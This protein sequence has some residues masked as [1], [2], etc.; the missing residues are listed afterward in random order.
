MVLYLSTS[1][2]V[3]VNHGDGNPTVV[4]G[5]NQQVNITYLNDSSPTISITNPTN[6]T[7]IDTS[8]LSSSFTI[9]HSDVN[10]FTNCLMFTNSGSDRANLT[11][12]EGLTMPFNIG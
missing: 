5:S 4:N 8:E 9:A 3:T 1:G 11:D 2:S 10:M 7:E 6:V 12:D